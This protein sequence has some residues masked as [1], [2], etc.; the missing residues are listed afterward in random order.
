MSSVLF[1]ETL[2]IRQIDRVVDVQGN[3][4]VP[5]IEWYS[6]ESVTYNVFVRR[7]NQHVAL[8]SDAYVLLKAWRSNDLNTLYINATGTLV[9]AGGNQVQVALTAG[10]ANLPTGSYFTAMQVWQG[11]NYMGIA[12][13][14]PL[15]LIWSPAGDSIAY[16]GSTQAP[17]LMRSEI[18]ISN[19]TSNGWAA[20]SAVLT[21]KSD[22]AT[23][24]G[25][26]GASNLALSASQSST[27]ATARAWA[28]AASNLALV[29]S[30]LALS[31]S[32]SST[33][34]TARA[35]ASAASN[36]ALVASNLALSASQS[37]TDATARAWAV[38]AS[39]RVAQMGSAGTNDYT[40]AV[41]NAA[42]LQG[43]TLA[44]TSGVNKL[45]IYNPAGNIQAQYVTG[46]GDLNYDGSFRLVA[47][48]VGMSN[49][50][51]DV[52]ASVSNSALLSAAA[53]STTGGTLSGNLAVDGH[54]RL[55]DAGGHVDLEA[56]AGTLLIDGDRAV[57]EN[58]YGSLGLWGDDAIPDLAYVATNWWKSA[59]YGDIDFRDSYSIT[60]I[61]RVANGS[62]NIDVQNGEIIGSWLFGEM[63]EI[64]GYQKQSEAF[65][66]VSNTSYI[67]MTVP[68]GGRVRPGWSY[69]Y[70]SD[71]IAFLT[72]FGAAVKTNK[73]V[74]SAG[75]DAGLPYWI[76][77]NEQTNAV[78][79]SHSASLPDPRNAAALTNLA[80]MVVP[81]NSITNAIA[82]LNVGVPNLAL[83][84]AYA[85][86]A[87]ASAASNLALVASNL[88]LSASQSSTDA[89]A[90]A[91]AQG[92]SNL[93]AAALS[94]TGGV[95]T[96]NLNMD[97]RTIT[98]VASIGWFSGSPYH[99]FD[100]ES[101]TA[102]TG[103]WAN[104]DADKLDGY[105]SSYYRDAANLTNTTAA[106]LGTPNAALSNAYLAKAGGSVYG[107]LY[108]TNNGYFT[109]GHTD[110]YT[111]P[112]VQIHSSPPRISILESNAVYSVLCAATNPSMVA[113]PLA[114]FVGGTA[115]HTIW[116]EGI[117]PDPR[118]A[119]A[120]TNYLAR[121]AQRGSVDQ[122]PRAGV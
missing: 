3:S 22:Y 75:L 40:N 58:N 106:G 29:A 120:L 30:N 24:A 83:S 49:L 111:T 61:Y 107:N 2:N 55:L 37:S 119:A 1:A 31:A 79:T 23:W 100:F 99:Y 113:G 36:L 13:Y 76:D 115:R 88:A 25:V 26:A 85:S 64:P 67:A 16:V 78:W 71:A 28:S 68:V 20:S 65:A 27:D 117:L 54:I 69:S 6:G 52:Q 108:I 10:Q 59:A 12:A 72:T 62:Q 116:D 56:D 91:W 90:R 41:F 105:D 101:G 63:P 93:A 46:Q 95:M 74:A 89:T 103:K 4:Q 57:V 39:N 97:D 38:A 104:L 118:N 33:D 66:P 122:L 94:T 14:A 43:T 86:H 44:L 60:N 35:W 21:L 110:G 98:N 34:A 87:S 109:V 121:P 80:A 102:G 7:A 73:L 19:G 48:A 9:A 45:L 47:N 114:R 50:A 81:T 42:K 84:N 8:P 70:Y 82:A 18:T 17:W 32:Q 11:T 15:R 92:A 96:G 112:Y 51:A 5:A 77:A 53:L